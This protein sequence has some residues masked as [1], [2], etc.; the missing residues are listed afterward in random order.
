MYQSGEN[1]KHIIVFPVQVLINA[2]L[3]EKNQ[4]KQT[5]WKFEGNKETLFQKQHCTTPRN[6]PT[7]K[8]GGG[9][10]MPWTSTDGR[11]F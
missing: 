7:M 3:R 2:D 6:K 9:S 1:T 10:I 4:Q 5:N 11:G 8:H